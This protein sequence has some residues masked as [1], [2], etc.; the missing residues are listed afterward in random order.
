MATPYY[1]KSR[2]ASREKI[3]ADKLKKHLESR[4]VKLDAK[5]FANYVNAIAYG[6]Y[7]Y[8]DAS[9]DIYARQ[10]GKE[11]NISPDQNRA[12]FQKAKPH[13]FKSIERKSDTGQGPWYEKLGAGKFI[14]SK[15][16]ELAQIKG[17]K[18]YTV[19]GDR[20]LST[21]ELAKRGLPT[22]GYLTKGELVEWE[23][24]GIIY[25]DEVAGDKVADPVTNPIA[26]PVT[27]PTVDPNAPTDPGI[28]SYEDWLKGAG[29][30]YANAYSDEALAAEYDPFYNRQ[31]GMEDLSKRQATDQ[32]GRNITDTTKFQ[33]E[34]AANSGLFGSGIYQQE[35]NRSLTDLNRGYEQQWGTGEY[36]PYSQRKF[37]IEQNKK[38]AI[39][40]AKTT[41]QQQAWDVYSQQYYPQYANQ[42]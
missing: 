10:Q 8:T 3:V 12:D 20:E 7:S 40:N 22:R 27:D 28:L 15:T 13:L 23:K 17:N 14:Q 42:Y 29:S 19:D 5:Y 39:A 4:G 24:Q 2:I 37:Q 34:S 16:G 32:L 6:G 21:S 33:G 36:T 26:D 1:G 30:S 18:F 41:R 25:G 11:G 31:L 35:L 38:T 9:N